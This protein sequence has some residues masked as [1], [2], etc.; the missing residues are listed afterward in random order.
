M[1]KCN[2]DRQRL[3]PNVSR[4]TDCCNTSVDGGSQE[5][6]Q[7]FYIV[8]NTPADVEPERAVA[9]D[10]TR[11][12]HSTCNS[13]E[14]GSDNFSSISSQNPSIDSSNSATISQNSTISTE[15]G[16]QSLADN[17]SQLSI[18]G[19]QSSSSSDSSSSNSDSDSLDDA[20]RPPANDLSP[21]TMLNIDHS[22]CY[23]SNDTTSV[24]DITQSS[25][26]KDETKSSLDDK[27]DQKSKDY[28]YFYSVTERLYDC[29]FNTRD[30][31]N[32]FATLT[33]KD[34]LYSKSSS[35]PCDKLDEEV[36]EII[37]EGEVLTSNASPEQECNLK[38]LINFDSKEVLH[39]PA[40]RYQVRMS[41]QEIS[42]SESATRQSDICSVIRAEN[43]PVNGRNQ[44]ASQEVA[45]LATS[46]VDEDHFDN[47]TCSE[48]LRG[49]LNLMNE[50]SYH[51]IKT[52][53]NT[54][55]AAIA[56]SNNATKNSSNGDNGDSGNG[57]ND[58]PSLLRSTLRT[59]AAALLYYDNISRFMK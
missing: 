19:V 55:N 4:V 48:N 49:E 43:P 51:R 59:G 33:D 25:H 20:L 42:C 44:S 17:F 39:P 10:C 21:N 22:T 26:L 41:P 7:S 35:G 2:R 46:T 58:F 32:E 50:N 23:T 18:T 34:I 45:S 29:S 9:V 56:N 5:H 16:S 31:E 54:S 11:N 28:S 13:N 15:V 47:P 1:E 53:S 36:V 12:Q 14:Q 30:P 24:N 52:D 57:N 40:S 6:S 38:D 3:F 37:D 8:G 27:S